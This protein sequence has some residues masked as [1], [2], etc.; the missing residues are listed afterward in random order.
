MLKS[1]HGKV[2]LKPK[3]HLSTQELF[4]RGKLI[5]NMIQDHLWHYKP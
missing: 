3:Y 1:K 2:L 4:F 5:K